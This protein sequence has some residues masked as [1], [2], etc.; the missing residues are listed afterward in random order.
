MTTLTNLA[1]YYMPQCPFCKKV[2]RIK[3][4]LGQ[5]FELRDIVENDNSR[6]E[7]IAGG[8]KKT[9]PCLQIADG[10][11]IQWMYESSDICDYL[12]QL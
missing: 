7:L 10:D 2:L 4:E 5:E 6:E 1:L 12:K 8:G 11:N 9:V 3:D